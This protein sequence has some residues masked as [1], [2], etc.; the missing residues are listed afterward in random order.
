M[1][2]EFTNETT[3]YVSAGELRVMY[4]DGPESGLM[5]IGISRKH[6]P[7][8]YLRIFVPSLDLRK[9]RSVLLAGL[10]AAILGHPLI[11]LLETVHGPR[12]RSAL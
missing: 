1:R 11:P 6:F 9:E 12:Q 3:L 8:D 4:E 2:Y 10:V 5:K 7:A